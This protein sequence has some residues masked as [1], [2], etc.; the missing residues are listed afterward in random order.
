[1]NKQEALDKIEELKEH[2]KSCDKVVMVPDCIK[3]GDCSGNMGIFFGDNQH[4]YADMDAGYSGYTV[5]SYRSIASEK[6]FNYKLVKCERSD[7]KRGD[8]AFMTDDDELEYIERLEMY[9]VMLNKDTHACVGDNEDAQVSH[10]DFDNWY[11][12]VEVQ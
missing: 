6:I 10:E 4:L 2:V 7:L 1:M 9:G 5:W 8:I 12:C 11:R 3:L